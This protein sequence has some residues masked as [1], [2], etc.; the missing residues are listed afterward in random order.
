MEPLQSRL[1]ELVHITNMD[2]LLQAIRTRASVAP[3]LMFAYFRPAFR[4]GRRALTLAKK[5]FAEQMAR[6]VLDMALFVEWQTRRAA[7]D[8]AP[9]TQFYPE[10]R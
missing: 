2:D 1:R 5:R 8:V 4:Q 10:K 7:E 6:S 3:A 9:Q